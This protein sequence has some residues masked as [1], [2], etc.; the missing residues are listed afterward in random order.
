MARNRDKRRTKEQQAGS[1]KPTD[2]KND[3]RAVP[4]AAVQALSYQ[5]GISP[6]S[7]DVTG[8]VPESIH[9]DPDL[10]EGHPGYEESG[11]SGIMPTDLSSRVNRDPT[12]DAKSPRTS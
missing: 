10:L 11:N 12:T 9:V 6:G 7:V 5:S 8:I 4:P 3:E 1:A 2:D